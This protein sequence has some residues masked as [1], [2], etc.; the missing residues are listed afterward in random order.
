MNTTG[1]RHFSIS[2]K[3]FGGGSSMQT[4]AKA[5]SQIG[6][7]LTTFGYLYHSLV[8]LHVISISLMLPSKLKL[9]LHG[10]HQST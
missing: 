8:Q 5:L 3:V 10:L 6:Q 4:I 2:N 7:F 1:T 9:K